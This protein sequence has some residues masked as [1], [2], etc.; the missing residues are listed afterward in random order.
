MNDA[1]RLDAFCDALWL[2]EGLAQNTLNSYRRDLSKVAAWLQRRNLDLL[3]AG[4]GDLLEFLAEHAPRMRATSMSRLLSSLRRFY[5][6]AVRQGTLVSDPSLQI[7]RPK[8]PRGLPKSISEAEVE[9]LLAA[10]P[11]DTALGMRDRALLE[12]LYA[13]GLRVSELVNLKLNEVSLDAGVVRIMGKGAKERLVPL[14]ENALDSVQL[15]LREARALLL[16][17]QQSSALFITARGGPMTRQMFWYLIKRYAARAGIAKTL[18]PHSLRH[19]FA[20][21]L[22]N[23]GA[24]LR[25]V[26]MLLG[27]ADIST[28]QI[29][30]HVARERLKHLHATHHPRG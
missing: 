5:Q 9:A 12:T 18:S 30:T 25:V 16:Q 20:T 21:H 14:G 24:D 1:M 22:L 10:P 17:G 15:Y 28:T 7:E 2:E 3:K 26:Q 6:Y 19:A 29:Y 23:H 8:L 4:H 11:T 27:H 13:S